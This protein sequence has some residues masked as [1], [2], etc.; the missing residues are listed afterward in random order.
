[1]SLEAFS[2]KFNGIAVL[3]ELNKSKIPSVNIKYLDERKLSNIVIALA[4]LSSI[5]F[6]T[7]SFYRNFDWIFSEDSSIIWI[8]SKCIGLTLTMALLLKDFGQSGNLI[9]KVCKIGKQADCSTIL[10]SR[11]ATVYGWVKWGDLGFIYFLSGLFLMSTYNINTITCLAL[12]AFPYV[13][14]SLYQQ[15]FLIKKLCLLCLG[16]VSILITEFIIGLGSLSNATISTNELLNQ[17]YYY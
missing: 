12:A 3:L 7:V 14:I 6:F 11:Y 10:E 15:L 1:M 5:A 17:P 2:S 4:V 13:F 9:N 8:S 16:V